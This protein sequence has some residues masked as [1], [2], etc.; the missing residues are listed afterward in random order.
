MLERAVA[1][2]RASRRPL[3]VAGGGVIYSEATRRPG[4]R[5]S[6]GPASPSARP[7]PARARCRWDHPR[8][9]GAIGATGTLAANRIA[10]HADL[11]IGIGTRYSRLHDRLEDAVPAPGRP[12]RQ[13]QR[14]AVRRR[15][16]R[17][18]AAGGRRPRRHRGADG[19]AGRA[20]AWTPATRPRSTDCARPG[21]RSRPPAPPGRAPLPA[22]AR[23][24]APSTRRPARAAWWS[25]RPAACPAT[26]TSS[27]GPAT[28]RQRLPPGVRLLLH[29]LRDRRRPRRQAGRPDPRGVR[30]GRRRLVP[31]DVVRDRDGRPGGH[32][33]DH[34]PDR[35][36]R[37][38][39]HRRTE[40]SRSG[41]AA[42]APSTAV[43]TRRPGS[44]RASRWWSTTLP[45]PGASAPRPSR[46]GTL[47][48]LRAGLERGPPH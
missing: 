42:S 33:A 11:V 40:R 39:Q 21:S 38:R 47:D 34:R 15:Q 12:L 26:C 45:T 18:R 2:I 24:S 19:G 5:S 20:T 23:S 4:R 35:Q 6:S 32:Q 37:L 9:L 3:I 14:R 17:R 46:P 25:A 10:A 41:A 28:R 36:W 16:A 43:A 7:R 48:E 27:G 1:L 13:R 31:A 8:N 22:R 29:G 44:F 30:D